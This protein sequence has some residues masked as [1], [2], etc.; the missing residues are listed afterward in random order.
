[1]QDIFVDPF[2]LNSVETKVIAAESPWQAGITGAN[3]RAF[4]LVLGKML[5]SMQSTD[6]EEQEEC[7]DATVSAGN[8]LLRTHGF[9]PHQHVFGRD[10]ELAFDVLM[11]GS[12]VA[13]VTMPVLDRPSERAIQIR[14]A[15]RQAFVESQDD[16][17]M[18]RA[19]V[20]RLRPWREFHVGDQIAFWRNVKGR[21]MRSGHAR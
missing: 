6:K 21:G 3:D 14:Q 8:V 9:S 16:K 2:Q 7:I 10:P 1:M 15:A 11:P 17:A 20:A 4:K 19:L 12:D 18:W 5:D 13:A